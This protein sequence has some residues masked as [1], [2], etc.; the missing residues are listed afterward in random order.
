M[1]HGIS[2]MDQ[3]KFAME[4]QLLRSLLCRHFVQIDLDALFLLHLNLSAV[5]N[6]CR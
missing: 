4:Q 1:I 3:S 2:S 6:I 5:A